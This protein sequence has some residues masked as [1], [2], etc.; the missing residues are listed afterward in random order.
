MRMTKFQRLVCLLL[1]YCVFFLGNAWIISDISRG[2]RFVGNHGRRQGG[3]I[4]ESSQKEDLLFNK[5]NHID[6]VFSLLKFIPKKLVSAISILLLASSIP[7]V[8]FAAVGEGDLPVGVQAF[9]RLLNAKVNQIF[10]I[11]CFTS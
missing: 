7:S 3:L 4:L 6:S 2:K 9:T 5:S 10:S 8:T 11:L 1:I